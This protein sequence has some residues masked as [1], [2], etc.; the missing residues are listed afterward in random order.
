MKPPS[1]DPDDLLACRR[2]MHATPKDRLDRMLWCDACRA[3]ERRR[4]RVWGIAIGTLAALALL[5]WIVL[6]VEA[7]LDYAL[8]W[9]LVVIVTFFLLTNLGTEMIYGI[10]RINNR[11]GAR[12]AGRSG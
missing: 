6:R 8:L 9:G 5:A 12:A 2:C 1:H 3:A 11:P 10:R 4:A 7:G